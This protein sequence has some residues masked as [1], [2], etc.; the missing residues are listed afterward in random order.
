MT[1]CRLCSSLEELSDTNICTVCRIAFKKNNG[2]WTSRVSKA[3][4]I[5]FCTKI[6]EKWASYGLAKNGNV[7]LTLDNEFIKIPSTWLKEENK[8]I[9]LLEYD[10]FDNSSLQAQINKLLQKCVLS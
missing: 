1:R 9:Q 7:W 2:K 8:F 10:S 6:S 4:N 5:Y 3:G